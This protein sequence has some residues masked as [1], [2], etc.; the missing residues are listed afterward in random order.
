MNLIM[1]NPKQVGGPPYS[2]DISDKGRG[3]HAFNEIK[4][5]KSICL[6]VIQIDWELVYHFK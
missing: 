5:I 3:A 6:L 1:N 2:S 4:R